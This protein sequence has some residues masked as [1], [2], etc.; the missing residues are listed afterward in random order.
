[1]A[2]PH[3][4]LRINMPRLSA[5]AVGFFTNEEGARLA[6]DM[7]GSGVQQGALSLD[8]CLDTLS[9]DGKSVREELSAIGYAGEHACDSGGPRLCLCGKR[10]GA[11]RL[12]C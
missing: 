6:P 7:M 3:S 10:G 11:R 4:S 12:A 1:M 5:L 8:E 2:N 9:I